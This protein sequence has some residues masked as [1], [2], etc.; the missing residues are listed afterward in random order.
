MHLIFI[1]LGMLVALLLTSSQVE[2]N[3]Y[4]PYFTIANVPKTFNDALSWCETDD[5]NF[6]SSLAVVDDTN[7]Q[8]ALARFLNSS[9]YSSTTPLFIDLKLSQQQPSTWYLVNGTAY[10]GKFTLLS[11]LKTHFINYL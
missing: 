7:T 8:M 11:H 6:N 9:S 2:A 5:T 3:S 1:C 4:E 10:K